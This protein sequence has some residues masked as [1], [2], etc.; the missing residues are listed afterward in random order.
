MD[1]QKP[2]IFYNTFDD[3][4][5][6]TLNGFVETFIFLL[7]HLGNKMNNSVDTETCIFSTLTVIKL[8]INC[9]NYFLN[10]FINLVHDRHGKQKQ[11]QK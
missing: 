11:K 4:E 9:P 1:S 10:N 5:N 3:Q 7:H 8:E 2:N 6:R